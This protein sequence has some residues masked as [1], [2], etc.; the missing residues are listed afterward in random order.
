MAGPLRA[1]VWLATRRTPPGRPPG[2]APASQ[3]ARRATARR[4]RP[5]AWP[6]R[7][8]LGGLW[9]PCAHAHL[10]RLPQV[11]RAGL[12]HAVAALEHVPCSVAAASPST[13]RRRR[14]RPGRRLC[15]VAAPAAS[16]H[17]RSSVPGHTARRA[18]RR[19]VPWPRLTAAPLAS[20][21]GPLVSLPRALN[22][23][24]SASRSRAR[25]RCPRAA[26]PWRHPVCN[27]RNGAEKRDTDSR[28]SCLNNREEKHASTSW[29]AQRESD[30]R[31]SRT[32][33]EKL[34]QTKDQ[35]CKLSSNSFL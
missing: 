32:S 5:A 30:A 27:R 24:A 17:A 29:A 19:A 13:G 4:A 34:P 31:R 22:S 33:L 28:S 26:P 20:C 2:R 7:A 10:G 35:R 15:H 11:G 23:R 3:P 8:C 18:R 25:P 12:T 1:G 9:R 14:R 21:A 16:P 6:G